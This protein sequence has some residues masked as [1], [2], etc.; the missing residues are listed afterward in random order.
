MIRLYFDTNLLTKSEQYPELENLLYN[1]QDKFLTLY[2]AA[3]ID[4]LSRSDDDEKVKIELKQIKKLTKSYSLSRNWGEDFTT[5]EVRDPVEFY[6]SFNKSEINLDSITDILSKEL[7]NTEGPLSILKNISH[8]LNLN[9][10]NE[11]ITQELGDELPEIFDKS[12]IDNTYYALLEDI[13][14]FIKLLNNDKKA[15]KALKAFFRKYLNLN[16]LGNQTNVL[17]FLNKELKK[18]LLGKDFN[19]L[20]NDA[21]YKPT[22]NYKPNQYDKFT[23]KYNSLELVGYRPDSKSSIPNIVTDSNHSYYAAHCDILI[24]E[25]R[26]LRDKSRVLYNEFRIQTTIY[27]LKE[28]L[29]NSGNLITTQMSFLEILSLIKESHH[30][31]IRSYC[32]IDGRITVHEF[33]PPKRLLNYFTNLQCEILESGVYYIFYRDKINY[34][35][36]MFGIELHKVVMFLFKL[37]GEDINQKKE[38]ESEEKETD[39]TTGKWIGRHWLFNE[40]QASLILND[41]NELNFLIHAIEPKEKEWGDEAL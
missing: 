25:D 22:E 1:N 37:L 30:N 18:S 38:I 35:N 31:L 27:S 28:F 24:T 7:M 19:E 21:L 29:E 8:N 33:I 23:S 13:F 4:D 2:S 20:A 5:Y 14:A 11:K 36:F 17:D 6:Q 15:S 41:Y 26:G 34:S 16:N 3:H 32:I 40:F 39:E 10:W 9:E 12:K